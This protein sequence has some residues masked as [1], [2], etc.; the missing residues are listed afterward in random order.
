M[1]SMCHI[2]LEN[3]IRV[4]GNGPATIP[5][6]ICEWSA[7]RVT[8]CK[9]PSLGCWTNQRVASSLSRPDKR[10]EYDRY[11]TGYGINS[12]MKRTMKKET[13]ECCCYN[14]LDMSVRLAR[15]SVIRPG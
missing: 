15:P 4:S 5:E 2:Q 7:A 11:I 6:V 13:S 9:G 8:S 1:Y 10:W 12:A 3:M 14:E